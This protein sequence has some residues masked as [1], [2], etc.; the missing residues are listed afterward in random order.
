MQFGGHKVTTS[1]VDN[2]SILGDEGVVSKEIFG[3]NWSKS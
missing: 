3:H 1:I 2:L